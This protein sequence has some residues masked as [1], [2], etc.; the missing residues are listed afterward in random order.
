[1]ERCQRC[2]V[3][4]GKTPEVKEKMR[5]AMKQGQWLV[6]EECHLHPCL[7]SEV[8]CLYRQQ[9]KKNIHKDFRLW[10]MTHPTHKLPA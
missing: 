6:I 9:M 8:W 5:N 1:M 4:Q 3:G 2:C 10:L 7:I